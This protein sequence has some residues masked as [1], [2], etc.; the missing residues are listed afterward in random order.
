M[1]LSVQPKQGVRLRLHHLPLHG[2]LNPEALTYT[3]NTNDRAL[4]TYSSRR[5]LLQIATAVV[6]N[7]D[8]PSQ[9]TQVH[10]VLDTGSQCSYITN[11]V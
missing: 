9:A 8:D 1:S 4:W 10:I 7:P 6:F 2:S 5:V 3:P 11:A